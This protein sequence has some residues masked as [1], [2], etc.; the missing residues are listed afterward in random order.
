MAV[1]KLANSWQFDFT[2][3]GYG[4]QRMA[5]F[6]TKT[7]AR[8]AERQRRSDLISGRKRI[9]F[10]DA[11][12]QYMS[13]TTMKAL[14]RDHWERCWPDIKPVLGHRFIEEVDTSALDQLKARLPSHLAPSSINHRLSLVRTIVR[15]MWKRGL[16]ASVPYV[17]M[18]SVPTTEP[19]WY[20]EKERDSLLDGMFR[21]QPR[22]YLFFYLTTRLGLRTGEVYAIARSRIR[23]IPPQLIVDRAVQRGTKDRP[24]LLGT[25]KNNKSLTLSLAQD[26][27]D[28]IRWHIKQGY[29]GQEFLFSADGTFPRH[30]DSHKR[31]LRTVQRALGL[32]E[33][34]HHQVGRHSVASQAATGGHSIKAIQAQLGH[35]SPQSTH[36][37]AHLGQ[38]A[39]LR[40]VEALQPV[41][42]PHVNVRSTGSDEPER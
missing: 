1:R 6:K 14:S 8:E 3:Q 25:R 38:Q 41:S 32:R 26:V 16:L 11:Y 21:L 17:P 20:G 23:D 29:S 2:L 9:L 27:V 13:A 37:Y 42:P 39:Q 12:A 24:A 7:E 22:W 28:A 30:L 19:V 31:P 4:R 33:L 34:S 18:E 15:F 36:L 10:A 5:G 40:L 35:Q